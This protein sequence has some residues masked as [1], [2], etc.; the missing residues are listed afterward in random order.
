M[1]SNEAKVYEFLEKLD[2][3]YEKTEH[4]AAETMV[5]CEKIN[6]VLDVKMCKNLFLCN[7]QKTMLRFLST[8]RPLRVNL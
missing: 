5:D 2:I 8:V 4:P 1:T 6:A 3:K 7:Q